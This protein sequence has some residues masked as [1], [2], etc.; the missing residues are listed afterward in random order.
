MSACVEKGQKQLT[1]SQVNQSR[2]ITKCR[3]I[4][5]VTNSFLKTSFRALVKCAIN[6]YLTNRLQNCSI[7]Y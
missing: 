6:V 5:E 1:T 2:M 3:W 7:P 4:I